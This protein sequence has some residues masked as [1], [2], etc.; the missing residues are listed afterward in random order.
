MIVLDARGKTPL[1]LQI[2]NRLRDDILSGEMA[3]GTKLPSGR[4]LAAE[5]A[6][7]RNTVELAYSRLADEGFIFGAPRV[8]Y[9]AETRDA[10]HT[11]GFGGSTGGA[12]RGEE[13]QLL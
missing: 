6:V 2:F 13:E 8:G 10:F 9:F 7:S 12:L 5:L 11:P 4:A 3:P 1:Y